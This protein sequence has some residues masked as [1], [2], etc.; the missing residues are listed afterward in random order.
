MKTQ[1]FN[2]LTEKH[3]FSPAVACGE[4]ANISKESSFNPCNLQNSYNR[5][6]GITDEEYV[7]QVDNGKITRAQFKSHAH[8]GFG[9]CQWTYHTRKAALYD[10]AKKQGKSIGDLE[11][12]VDFFVQELKKSFKKTYNKLMAL[13]NTAEGAYEAGY[14]L[15]YE[16]EAP[17]KKKTSSPKRGELAKEFFTDYGIPC[18]LTVEAPNKVKATELSEQIKALGY[19]ATIK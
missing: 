10:F 19:T 14:I 1:I 6:L 7:K 8:G 18:T 12:Q 11:M 17:A 2:I 15:C 3:G 9:L 5:T 4:L 13:P 16:Y